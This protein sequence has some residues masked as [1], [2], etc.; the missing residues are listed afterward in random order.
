MKKILSVMLMIAMLMTSTVALAEDT[1]TVYS[2]NLSD[3]QMSENDE[4]LMDLTGMTVSL[5]AGV[6]D[7]GTEGLLSGVD[8]AGE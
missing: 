6:D 2:I 1:M 5:G 8:T 4:V 7:N 3:I